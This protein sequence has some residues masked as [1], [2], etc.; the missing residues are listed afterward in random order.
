[1]TAKNYNRIFLGAIRSLQDGHLDAR[2]LCTHLA[3]LQGESSAWPSDAEFA[4]AWSERHA[5]QTLQQPKI[6]LILERLNATYWTT[7][8]EVMAQSGSLTVEHLMPQ[9]WV[10]HWLLADGQRGLTNMELWTAPEGD[11]RAAACRSRNQLLQTMGNLTL[12]TQPLNSALSNG[13]WE[14]KRRELLLHSSLP[15]NQQLQSADH[16]N[17]GAIAHRSK[18]LLRRAFELW[19]SAP[20]MLR[21]VGAN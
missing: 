10:E 15:L 7:K 19:P 13:P 2:G 18:E 9:S 21:E 4:T 17:E 1:M 12:V 11:A 14:A 20:T 5:Y 8:A 6:L 16:W 3:S